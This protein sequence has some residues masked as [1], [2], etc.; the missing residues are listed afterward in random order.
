[1]IFSLKRY[2]NNAAGVFFVKNFVSLFVG[3]VSGQLVIILSSPILSR[4]YSPADFGLLEIIL[5]I[6]SII[7]VAVN[8]RF[9]NAIVIQKTKQD[10]DKI[11]F[12]CFMI[13]SFMFLLGISISYILKYNEFIFFAKISEW[14]WA[15]SLLGWISGFQLALQ[16][17]FIYQKKYKLISFLLFFQAMGLVVLQILYGYFSCYNSSSLILGYLINNVMICSAFLYSFLRYNKCVFSLDLKTIYSKII[18]CKN[19]LFYTVPTSLLGAISQRGLFLTLGVFFAESDV[20]FAGLAMRVM[21]FPITLV[22]RSMA[23]VFFGMFSENRE[24]V[25]FAHQINK[26]LRIK[27]TAIS[28]IIPLILSAPSLF[29]LCF[30]AQW[31]EA[32]YYAM[33]LSPAAFMLFLTGWLDR[34]HDVAALQKKAFTLEIIYDVFLVLGMTTFSYVFGSPLYLVGFFGFFTAA[35]NVVWLI[36]TVKIIGISYK[37]SFKNLL[38]LTACVGGSFLLYMLLQLMMCHFLLTM[39]FYYVLCGI[40]FFI[41]VQAP[42]ILWK[43]ENPSIYQRQA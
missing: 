33:L 36:L 21:Y 2:L 15:P 18:E 13:N 31:K 22:T 3:N 27:I 40:G 32:G 14:W 24:N 8:W 35:Y 6:F 37:K 4:L 30:G 11:L 29:E 34:T 20:G 5:S 17:Y 7:F 42:R 1:M 9:E 12:L 28:L 41:Y 26:I 38:L 10:A 16:M 19:F 39:L 25:N 23:Q 43:K